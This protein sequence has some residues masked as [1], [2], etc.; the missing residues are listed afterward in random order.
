MAG[1]SIPSFE[2]WPL[3]KCSQH[4]GWL[5]VALTTSLLLAV[6]ARTVTSQ[7]VQG[8]LTD[9]STGETV[10]GALVL[11]IG[12]EGSEVGGYLTNQAGR[13]IIQ[14]PG[15]G[16]FTLRAER[17]GYATIESEPFSLPEA[18]QLSI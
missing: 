18:Q 14:A 5:V 9:P 11:L 10:E 16:T 13:F 1:S 7:T 2:R 17:I 6:S 12:E 8:Q 15:P 4:R 3:G